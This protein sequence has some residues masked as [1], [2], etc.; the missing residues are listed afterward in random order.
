MRDVETSAVTPRIYGHRGA[1]GELPENSLAGLNHLLDIGV[2]AAEI[3]VQNSADGVMVVWHVHNLNADMVRDSTGAWVGTDAVLVVDTDF[4]DLRALDFGALRENSSKSAAAPEQIRL[5]GTKIATLDDVCQW[6]K[7]LDGFVMNVEI[8]SFADRADWGHSPE[9]L[10]RSFVAL[11]E[12]YDLTDHVIVSSFDWRVLREIKKRA[13][14]IA[15][16]YLSYL[17]RPNP[18]MDPNIIDGSA[19]ID[20][21]TLDDHDGSLPQ[22]IADMGG[23]VWA[24]YYEDLTPDD[25]ARAHELGLLVNVWTVNQAD[26]MKRMAD[27]GVDG[28]ITDYPT[29]ASQVFGTKT[30]GTDGTQQKTVRVD[31]RV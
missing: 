9:V 30:R 28:V 17:D 31:G 13:E 20:G 22:D 16:G 12:K 10:A 14:G 15:R 2:S 24:P 1:R 21:L 25:L 11:I 19:W 8:K 27:M 23:A 4:S 7:P 26:D 6:L 18:P 3:D 29:L 5:P